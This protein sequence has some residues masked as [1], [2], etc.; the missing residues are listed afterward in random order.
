LCAG[1]VGVG[2]IVEDILDAHLPQGKS[3]PRHILLTAQV[4]LVILDIFLL[5]TEA[6]SLADEQPRDGH[7]RNLG[8]QAEG[9]AVGKAFHAEGLAQAKA[10]P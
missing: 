4:K 8:A 10:L 1:I 3:N 2:V 7:I 5:A 9:F 6:D